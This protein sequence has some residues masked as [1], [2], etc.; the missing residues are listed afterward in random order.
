MATRGKPFEPG[1]KLG[2]G[3]PRGS[4]NKTTVMAQELLDS[5]AEPLVKKCLHQALQG[6]IKAMQICMDRVLPARRD[7]PVKIG[8]FPIH[9]AADVSRA[10][11]TVI[12]KVAAG[13][14]TPIQGKVFADLIE[15]RRRTIETQDIDAR[16]QALEAEKTI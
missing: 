5:F 15:G 11:E 1:N 4:R 13:Q 12:E 7:L 9:T 2:R 8:K 3:R 16:L 14:I 6:D 10:S